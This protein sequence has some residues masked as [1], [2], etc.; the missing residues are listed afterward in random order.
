MDCCGS[1]SLD[2]F[3]DLVSSTEMA[4]TPISL[5]L[6]HQTAK[7]PRTG[8]MVN[9]GAVVTKHLADRIVGFARLD[10]CRSCRFACA[11]CSTACPNMNACGSRI[12]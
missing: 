7:P 9:I 3:P 10:L 8:L 11:P 5:R 12:T 6:A 1:D 4:E 2:I